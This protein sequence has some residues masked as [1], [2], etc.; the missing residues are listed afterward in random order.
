MAR[1]VTLPYGTPSY[2]LAL[3][4]GLYEPC[5]VR[6]RRSQGLEPWDWSH[7]LWGLLHMRLLYLRS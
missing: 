6:L 2:L 3:H 5:V 4:C 7:Q 1:A